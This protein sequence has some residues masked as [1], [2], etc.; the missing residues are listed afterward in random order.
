MDLLA[1]ILGV[2]WKICYILLCTLLLT[3]AIIVHK[4]GYRTGLKGYYVPFLNAG[5]LNE[6]AEKEN[7]RKLK[8]LYKWINFLIPVL[9]IGGFLSMLYASIISP[10]RF[11]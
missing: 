7:S 11:R 3:R 2:V 4:Y 1:V 10:W 9:L 8:A 6:I 5:I